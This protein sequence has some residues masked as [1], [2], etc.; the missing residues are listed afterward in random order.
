MVSVRRVVI[1]TSGARAHA[2]T[3]KAEHTDPI[4]AAPKETKP[5]HE[6]ANN[7]VNNNK[8]QTLVVLR[9]IETY[10]LLDLI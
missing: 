1:I 7:C 10:N 6:K 9:S 2:R 4:R 8:A 3:Q 5:N